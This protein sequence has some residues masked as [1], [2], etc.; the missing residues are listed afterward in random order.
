MSSPPP[1]SCPAG[2]AWCS[3]EYST[4]CLRG[5]TTRGAAVGVAASSSHTSLVSELAMVMTTYRSL[6]VKPTP[7]LNRWSFSSITITSS[8][9]GV[10]TRWRH[11]R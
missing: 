6:R 1:P 4:P 8:A 7:T 5:S 2:A 3:T 10:P 9:T 11:T